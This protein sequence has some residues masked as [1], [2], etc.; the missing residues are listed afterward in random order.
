MAIKR[1]PTSKR[2]RFEVFKRDLFT[3]QYCGAR[4][5]EVVLVVDHIMPV[6]GGGLTDID[7]LISACLACNQGKADKPLT[8]RVIRPDADLLYLETQ[9]EIVEL[10]RY[11]IAKRQRDMTLS[12]AVSALQYTWRSYSGCEWDP[13]E[14][15]ILHILSKYD[16]EVVEEAIVNVAIKVGG[17]YL[18]A[19]G[20][21]W[22]MYLYGVLRNKAADEND[23]SEPQEAEDEEDDE[24][25]S[26]NG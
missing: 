20:N 26:G 25:G 7:N 8:D 21:A 16:P 2:L 19:H 24:T 14:R 22:L 18:P 9:Q 13:A 6:V 17:R 11:L 5:P 1:L 10:Q 12:T 4:P 15:V 3:C 23:F